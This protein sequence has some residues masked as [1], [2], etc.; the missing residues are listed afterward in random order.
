V[1]EKGFQKDNFNEDERRILDI[2]FRVLKEKLPQ[3]DA[4]AIRVEI[5][6]KISC[7]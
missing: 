7:K 3:G 4:D 2:V 6:R 1:P 5:L